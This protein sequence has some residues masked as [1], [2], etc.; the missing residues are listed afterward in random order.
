MVL[1]EVMDRLRSMGDA[2]IRQINARQGAGE[3]QFGVKLGDI[4]TLAK[5]IKTNHELAMELWATG[6]ADAMFLATLLMRPKLLS[7]EELDR[8]AHSLTFTR[9]AD[10]FMDYVVKAHPQKEALRQKWVAADHPMAA[11]AYWSLTAERIAKNPDGLDLSA[12]LDRIESEMPGAP[13]E[14]QWTMNFALAA[15]G[16]NHPGYRQRAIDIGEKLGIYRDYPT[17]KGCTSPFA[18]TWIEE[19][20]KRQG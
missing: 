8:M 2:K 13:A 14:S 1:A 12:L 19:M 9:V 4:R 20:V 5:S 11:R 18:P 17:S 10:W 15:I 3:N 6:N 7:E 16:I